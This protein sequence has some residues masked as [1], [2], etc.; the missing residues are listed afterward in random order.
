MLLDL[1]T[2]DQRTGPCVRAKARAVVCVNVVLT[3]NCAPDV[4][5]DS[6]EQQVNEADYEVGEPLPKSGVDQ[7][8]HSLV[9]KSKSPSVL[10]ISVSTSS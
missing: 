6:G 1:S 2:P 10:K 5:G 3:R 4:G 9:S 8:I 7:S